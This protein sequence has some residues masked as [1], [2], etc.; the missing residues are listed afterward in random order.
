MKVMLALRYVY[1]VLC[2]LLPFPTFPVSCTGN[3]SAAMR[4]GSIIR[5]VADLLVSPFRI[6]D[7]LKKL[8]DVQKKVGYSFSPCLVLISLY[9]RAYSP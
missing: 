8:Y 9:F 2:R 7:Q 4:V 6:C 5:T 1:L 3:R